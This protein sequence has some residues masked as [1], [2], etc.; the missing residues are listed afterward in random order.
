MLRYVLNSFGVM[1]ARPRRG[2]VG[3]VVPAPPDFG[4]L[5]DVQGNKTVFEEKLVSMRDFL[6]RTDS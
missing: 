6:C 5:E 1:A 4:A 2:L 3:V